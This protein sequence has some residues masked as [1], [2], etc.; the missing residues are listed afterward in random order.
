VCF[1]FVLVFFYKY[2]IFLTLRLTKELPFEDDDRQ[3][4]FRSIA[5][6]HYD[7]NEKNISSDA[8]DL[9]RTIHHLCLCFVIPSMIEPFH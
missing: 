3:A 4:L 6:G 5:K 9:V 8:K 1:V 2:Y 7:L